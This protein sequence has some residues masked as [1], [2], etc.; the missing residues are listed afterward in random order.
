MGKNIL[1]FLDSI[2]QKKKDEILTS[3]DQLYIPG[4][5]YYVSAEGND[6][7]DGLSPENPWKT[8]Q[9]VSLFNFN[10]GDGV[11]FR[12]GDTFR[13]SVC[14]HSNISYGAYGSGEKPRFYG[15]DKNLGDPML[16]VEINTEN[17]IWKYGEKILDVG[18][19][20]FGD[21]EFCSRKLIHLS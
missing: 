11:L 2:A 19:L 20:V 12:R 6:E 7:N 18:T 14:T 9:K 16:W 10:E 8:L 5:T 15:W 1:F 17:H 21:D 4:N 13:G 3:V